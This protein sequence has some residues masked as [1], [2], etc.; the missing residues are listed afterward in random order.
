VVSL[1]LVVESGGAAS[2]PGHDAC[3]RRF[4]NG[5]SAGDQPLALFAATNPATRSFLCNYG[6]FEASSTTT[7]RA[8]TNTSQVSLINRRRHV[9]GWPYPS[10]SSRRR[11]LKKSLRLG[12]AKAS[13]GSGS[14]IPRDRGVGD[15]V[16]ARRSRVGRFSEAVCRYSRKK[17]SG[18]GAPS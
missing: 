8:L 4:R 15:F 6:R 7:R 3:G 12:Y 16:T 9:H 18:C 1:R 14:T 2:S 17:L 5:V 10:G 11:R 13:A